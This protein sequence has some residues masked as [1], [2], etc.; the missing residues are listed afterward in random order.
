MLFK[1]SFRTINDVRL[2]RD[3][4]PVPFLPVGYKYFS[5][6]SMNY[7]PKGKLQ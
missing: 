7:H 1:I 5:T 4:P 6:L 2:L 3:L